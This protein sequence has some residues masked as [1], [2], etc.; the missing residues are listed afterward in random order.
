MM[1]ATFAL[2]LRVPLKEIYAQERGFKGAPII[3]RDGRHVKLARRYSS[4]ITSSAHSE[5]PSGLIPGSYLPIEFPLSRP[6]LNFPLQLKT[7]RHLHA[8]V[9]SAYMYIC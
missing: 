2:H 5:F 4:Y 3:H 7:I 1:Q 9:V 6:F 8:C